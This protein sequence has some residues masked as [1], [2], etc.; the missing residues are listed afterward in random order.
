MMTS[1]KNMGTQAGSAS[2]VPKNPLDSTTATKIPVRGAA[3][4]QP[5]SAP[6][7]RSVV[8]RKHFGTSTSVPVTQLH[9]NR[10][11][12]DLSFSNQMPSVTYWD[13]PIG[14]WMP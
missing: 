8:E 12:F 9:L 5:P 11:T 10:G 13:S 14:Y 6:I 1:G 4:S 7:G 3:V 2:R